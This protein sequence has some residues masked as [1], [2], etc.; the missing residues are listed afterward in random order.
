M[1]SLLVVFRELAI[2]RKPL[3][4]NKDEIFNRDRKIFLLSLPLISRSPERSRRGSR[5]G[6]H[7]GQQDN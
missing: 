7:L 3:L 5:M 4:I 2:V 6:W 1:V